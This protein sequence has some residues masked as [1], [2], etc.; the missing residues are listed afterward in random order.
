MIA[1]N[2]WL[3]GVALITF[4]HSIKLKKHKKIKKEH[5]NIMFLSFFIKTLMYFHK[6]FLQSN[7]NCYF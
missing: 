7:Q 2:D 4:S 3:K 1:P 5:T 6:Q